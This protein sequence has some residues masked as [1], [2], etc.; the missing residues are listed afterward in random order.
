M[1]YKYFSSRKNTI[2]FTNIILSGR[3]G[4]EI[5]TFELARA[6]LMRGHRVAI[7][8]LTLGDLAHQ[9]RAHGI[10]VTDRITDINFTPNI[11]HGHHN[12]T[13]A[14]AMIR[15]PATPAIFVCHDSSQIFDEPLL[16][17]RIGQY[18][19]VDAACRERMI[20][21]GVS[22]ERIQIIQNAV[23]TKSFAL[24]E[25]WN[26]IPRTALLVCKQKGQHIDLVQHACDR[27]GIT[28]DIVGPGIRRVVTDMPRRNTKADV[29]FAYSR[30][31]MEAICTGA[32]T[33]I[34][35]KCGYG[36]IV[37]YKQ[38]EQWPNTCL[39]ARALAPL[40]SIE[41][42]V[43]DILSYDPVMT[44]SISEQFRSQADLDLKVLEFEKIYQE[45][46]Q[47]SHLTNARE[48]DRTQ[49][50]IDH[51]NAVLADFFS[52]CVPRA[53]GKSIYEERMSDLSFFHEIEGI[54]NNPALSNPEPILFSD[55]GSGRLF[56]D[57]GWHCPEN[58]GVWSSSTS[59]SLL[60][61]RELIRGYAT[62]DV[63]IWHMFQKHNKTLRIMVNDR[64]T[65]KFPLTPENGGEH[66][67][68]LIIPPSLFHNDK[69][70]VRIKF[71][72]D[73]VTSPL[74]E[75]HSDDSRQL[76]IGLCALG[77]LA[78]AEKSYAQR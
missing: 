73:F 11:I 57:E 25:D 37:N 75:G 35:D 71:L 5:Y 33:I 31:A 44:R 67:L 20:V 62:L 26:P 1:T 32:H 65:A 12:V 68:P 70:F 18:I 21:C 28:L 2:L 14:I 29:V 51:D 72:I 54:F 58:W 13:S 22:E 24:R 76:G 23:D 6:M 9:A 34:I 66:I 61:P 40:P 74:E 45:V 50:L 19:A 78:G 36:G 47:T 10:P 53:I 56:L 7:Y 69:R 30:S 27:A 52:H 15:F 48:N 3:T 8:S 41:E 43:N 39:S 55:N 4:T 38:I 16:L 63:R 42:L 60:I 59:S 77:S 64:V 49:T 17:N 46:I